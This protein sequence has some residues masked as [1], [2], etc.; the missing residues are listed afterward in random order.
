[1]ASIEI[2][3][4]MGIVDGIGGGSFQPDA[5]VL[6]EQV[7]K[8]AICSIEY[9]AVLKE[10]EYPTNY[11]S[12]ASAYGLIN[13]VTSEIGEPMV[14]GEIAI[15]IENMLKADAVEKTYGYGAK[16]TFSNNTVM[17]ELLGIDEFY[18]TVTSNEYASLLGEKTTGKGIVRITTSQ[19]SITAGAGVLD[20]NADLGKKGR[21]YIKDA[22]KDEAK[23]VHFRE[24]EN[25][26]KTLQIDAEN[27]SDAEILDYGENIRLNYYVN[28]VKKNVKMSTGGKVFINGKQIEPQNVTAD[29]FDIDSGSITLLSISDSG[30]DTAFISSYISLVVNSVHTKDCEVFFKP[31]LNKLNGKKVESLVLDADDPSAV[32]TLKLDGEDI[33]VEE[34]RELDVLTVMSSEDEELIDITVSRESTEGTVEKIGDDDNGKYCFINGKQY[35]ISN[36]MSDTIKVNDNGTFYIDSFGKIVYADVKLNSGKLYGYMMKSYVEDGGEDYVMRVLTQEG[37]VQNIPMRSKLKF[38]DSQTSSSNVC[39]SLGSTGALIRYNVNGDG[40]MT[41]VY[42]AVDNGSSDYRGYDDD[43][44]SK[45]NNTADGSLYFKNTAIPGFGGRYMIGENTVIFTVPADATDYDNYRVANSGYFVNDIYYNVDIYD[46]DRAMIA[47]AVVSKG[48]DETKSEEQSLSWNEPIMLI[49]KVDQEVDDDNDISWMVHGIKNGK[50][51]T[52]KVA[53]ED[54]DGNAVVSEEYGD[55]QRMQPDALVRGSII[56][57]KTNIDGEMD[58]FRVLYIPGSSM[59]ITNL[60]PNSNHKIEC[61]T[62][63]GL[64]DVCRDGLLRITL[65]EGAAYNAAT[66]KVF[67]IGTANIYRF[68]SKQKRVENATVEDIRSRENSGDSASRVFVRANKENV[69]DIVIYE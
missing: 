59:R 8:I 50:D 37:E 6:T 20:I 40:E 42:T 17:S 1:K 15:L 60:D 35:F 45:D 19:E 2:L 63:V 33:S 49:D 34:L 58:D 27:F 9:D 64:A 62:V 29:I 67:A 28:N 25:G 26:I 21:F 24:T 36:G 47:G 55:W 56:Q 48:I 39:S 4:G 32:F 66:G 16:V 14:R 18:G 5:P 41:S 65:N 38:N 13:N 53:E 61:Q 43:N 11:I 57:Y 31:N 52:V 54:S 69:G 30:Y 7:I 3:A 68:D 51:V 12:T 46:T 44:F 10:G 22:E 23:I